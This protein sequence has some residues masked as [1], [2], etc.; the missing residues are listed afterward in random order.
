ME[1]ILFSD[2]KFNCHKKC[3]PQVP[4]DCAGELPKVG[5][6]LLIASTFKNQENNVHYVTLKNQNFHSP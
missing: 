4:K 1:F 3:A 5:C 6:K 2:C